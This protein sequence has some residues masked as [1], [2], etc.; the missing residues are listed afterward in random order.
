MKLPF[1]ILLF[2]TA[3]LSLCGQLTMAWAKAT[4]GLNIEIGFSIDYD[5]E[6]NTITSGFFDGTTDF[7]PGY[8]VEY[9]L[10]A[11]NGGSA[12]IMKLDPLGN[13]IWATSIEGNSRA[14]S[15]TMDNDDNIYICGGFQNTID[16]DSGPGVVELTSAGLNDGY[17]AKYNSLGEL[18][19]AKGYG[20]ELNETP[21]ALAIDNDGN[22]V[23]T[24][25]FNAVADFDPSVN[26][27]LLTP[28][29]SSDVFISKFDN[30]GNFL[31]AKQ[32]TGQSLSSDMS[33]SAIVFGNEGH[34]YLCG[35]FV[36]SVDFDPGNA[37]ELIAGSTLGEWDT[38]ILRLD[39]DGNFVWV[40]HF[41]GP[42]YV[43]AYDMTL[44]A[45]ENIFATG[46]FDGTADFD[47]SGDV[48]NLTSNGGFDVY[49]LKLDSD[50]E[51]VW[52]KNMGGINSDLGNGIFA[53]SQ[54][55][56]YT[57]GYF[58]E[59]ADFD[60]SE[61]SVNIVTHGSYDIFVSKLNGEGE[62]VW[63]YSFGGSQADIG[64]AICVNEV[65]TV[66][67]TGENRTSS[68]FDPNSSQITLGGF[69]SSA[70][71][72][73]YNQENFVGVNNDFEVNY[74]SVF[75]NPANEILTVQLNNTSTHEKLNISIT[76]ING[77]IVWQG[78]STSINQ[79]Q[80]DTSKLHEGI[81]SISIQGKQTN[82][83]TLFV[84]A[85]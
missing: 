64:R 78:Q 63:A 45:S 43:V 82:A 17:L 48:M 62:F 16:F 83:T 84:V 4:A 66:Y 5:S 54:G 15:M 32:L 51:F 18:L 80:I 73:T 57:T 21:I 42:T 56:V 76:D 58:N 81:Y 27:A 26:Q 72:V 52:V 28:V 3:Q 71:T 65:G 47:P 9:E 46:Y 75:P 77:K 53:D 39:S 85:R 11:S 22:L 23:T 61:N 49:V 20:G 74:F 8:Q 1:T 36:N 10:T 70:Y 6:G 19:W 13:F 40:K 30:D 69:E 29:G 35:R 14:Y 24:G 25:D 44:D 59:T 12:F 67:I 38:F 60:P 55:A 33:S 34:I 68:Y 7:D 31:W 37:I 50:G 2:A 41:G 79:K